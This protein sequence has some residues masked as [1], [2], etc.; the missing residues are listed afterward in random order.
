[1]NTPQPKVITFGTISSNK[2]DGF[3]FVGFYIDVDGFKG[4]H[5][6]AIISAVIHRLKIELLTETKRF[7]DRDR[8]L[9]YKA[10]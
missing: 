6:M 8:V 1:M 10:D 7:D 4:S 5:E 3:N 9:E 2:C